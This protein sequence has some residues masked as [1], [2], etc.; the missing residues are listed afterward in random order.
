[1]D[2]KINVYLTTRE[3][4]VPDLDETKDLEGLIKWAAD[5]RRHAVKILEDEKLDQILINKLKDYTIEECYA[6]ITHSPGKSVEAVHLGNFVKVFLKANSNKLLWDLKETGLSAKPVKKILEE[7]PQINPD[8]LWDNFTFGL[9]AD[10]QHQ[11]E[12]FRAYVEFVV[13]K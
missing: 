6:I 10:P 3:D 5:I 4:P 11:P 12:E 9:I 13:K 8:L 1:M 7:N 2:I